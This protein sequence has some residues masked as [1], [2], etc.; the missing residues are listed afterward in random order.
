M[1]ESPQ[2]IWEAEK[3]TA[4]LLSHRPN[5]SKKDEMFESFF[6]RRVKQYVA[7]GRTMNHRFLSLVFSHW[8]RCF[9][10]PRMPIDEFLFLLNTIFPRVRWTWSEEENRSTWRL[11]IAYFS[12]FRSV[13]RV[14]EWMRE[15]ESREIV[16]VTFVSRFVRVDEVRSEVKW[17]SRWCSSLKPSSLWPKPLMRNARC[18]AVTEGY[19]VRFHIWTEKIFCFFIWNKKR[20]KE[21]N[22]EKNKWK[23][24]FLFVHRWCSVWMNRWREVKRIFVGQREREKEENDLLSRV[25]IYSNNIKTKDEKETTMKRRRRRRSIHFWSL[26]LCLYTSA[27]VVFIDSLNIRG[28]KPGRLLANSYTKRK[29]NAWGFFVAPQR[30]TYVCHIPFCLAYKWR[31][32]RLELDLWDSVHWVILECPKEVVWWWSLVANLSPRPTTTNRRFHS[33]SNERETRSLFSSSSSVAIR[34]HRI[35]IRV[36]QWWFEFTFRGRRWIIVFEHHP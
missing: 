27:I 13:R 18:S 19:V 30:Q 8:L 25:H 22:E 5:S 29:V 32:L 4:G 3:I 7:R 10:P 9:V 26:C 12:F 36:K 24:F 33:E 28:T 31:K 17:V 2:W 6:L 23:S 14:G 15:R 34:T 16:L 11:S 20:K 1:N 35:D 21:E